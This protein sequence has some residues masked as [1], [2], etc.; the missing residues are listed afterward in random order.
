MNKRLLIR[1]L[2]SSMLFL[3]FL[4]HNRGDIRMGWLERLEQL[5]YDARLVVA[6]PNT[7][8]DRI[9]ILDL[10]E[11]SLLEEGQWPW[12]R[13]RMARLVNR[14][15][16]DYQVKVL[17]F[18]IVFAEA[19][20]TSGLPV[21][22]RLAQDELRNVPQF[23]QALE[24]LRPVLDTDSVFAEA[25][26]DRA[27][28]LGYVF[29]H[30]GDSGEGVSSGKLPKPLIPLDQHDT[31]IP[32]V[33]AI[34]Y[35]GNIAKLQVF[36]AGGFFENALVDRDGKYRR[37]P[38]LQQHNDKI[39]AS[40]ALAVAY[41]AL[42]RPNLDFVFQHGADGPRDGLDLDWLSLGDKKIPIDENASVL[43]PYRGQV[44]SF[45]Y[46]SAADVLHGRAAKY[47]LRGAIVLMGA[48]AAGLHDL[49]NT[50]IGDRFTGVEIH[51]NIVSGILDETIMHH[52]RYVQGIEITVLFLLAV[53][54]TAVLPRVPV[55][56]AT[57]ATTLISLLI[58]VLNLMIWDRGNF[59]LPLASFLSFTFLLY[60]LHMIYGYF[61]EARGMRELSGLFGQYVPPELVAEMGNNPG[62]FSMA[63]ES[64]EMTVMFADIRKFTGIA[65][66]LSP[67]EVSEFLNAFLTPMTRVI[68]RHRGTIDKYMGDAIMAFWGAPVL[69]EQ[70]ARNALLS[71]IEMQGALS[72]LQKGFGRRGW[73]EIKIGIGLNTGE[74]RVGNMG[75][76]FRMAYTVMGDSV[77]LGERLENLTK[78]YGVTIA[79]G[80]AT[81]KAV[82][83]FAF[84]E[85]DRV[86]VKGKDK[87]VAIFSPVGPRNEM[88]QETRQMLKKHAVALQFY[89]E[90][91]WDSAEKEFF[92]LAQSFPGRKL[93][94]LYLDRVTYFRGNPPTDDW[95][96]ISVILHK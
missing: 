23:H 8:D 75:S 53:L 48:S 76:S 58:I 70:H 64:R 35:T 86:R 84:L 39:Y 80:E 41:Q 14:L 68:Q 29:R 54:L 25:L 56:T 63:S 79:V 77:N 74:M 92:G 55:M 36:S 69:D 62:D 5:A 93:F 67:P 26:A 43:V 18:D 10:D 6:M 44:G 13:D 4:L 88:G 40:L 30:A 1:V 83:D 91:D 32:F 45:P 9:V 61:V 19:D 17:G 89:R 96:G 85:L 38:L 33:E 2:I 49:R 31:D 20:K 11:K 46:V 51:A 3:P 73:P 71:A 78:T 87:S 16:D 52:P 34:A 22:E 15:F 47:P 7:V 60:F 28:V 82:P 42:G 57:L 90:R 50:P 12:P 65:E 94:S 66:Q 21:L 37:V 95:D 27:T 24:R 81:R 59:V 72:E